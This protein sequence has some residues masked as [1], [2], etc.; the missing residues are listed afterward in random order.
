M[1]PTSKQDAPVY[2]S[3]RGGALQPGLP[4]VLLLGSR[5][6]FGSWRSSA[7]RLRR[8]SQASKAT[9]TSA[10]P[11]S[12]R[13]IGAR[14]GALCV[15][16]RGRGLFPKKSS[17]GLRGDVLPFASCG[18]GLAHLQVPQRSGALQGDFTRVAA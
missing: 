17:E 14:W 4:R 11:R 9:I 18:H 13:S 2:T 10:I 1:L 3:C 8:E 12:R 15:G 16:P 5:S 7:L 6:H